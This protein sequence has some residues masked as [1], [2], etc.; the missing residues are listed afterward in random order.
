VNDDINQRMAE[1]DQELQQMGY[2]SLDRLYK[3]GA[4]LDDI[5]FVGWMAGLGNWKPTQ[6]RQAA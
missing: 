4:S 3:A 5:Q 1:A 6:E 2:E